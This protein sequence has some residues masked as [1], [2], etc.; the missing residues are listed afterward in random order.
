[1]AML[2]QLNQQLS[3]LAGLLSKCRDSTQ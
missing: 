1:M 2:Q 3:S